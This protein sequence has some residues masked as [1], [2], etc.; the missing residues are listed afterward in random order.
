[1][2]REKSL[3]KKS[4][5]DIAGLAVPLAL[6]A[7][8]VIANH[9]GRAEASSVHSGR[10]IN[11]V[12]Y[13]KRKAEEKQLPPKNLVKE[14]YDEWEQ[15]RQTRVFL[16]YTEKDRQKAV[17]A[18]FGEARELSENAEYLEAIA[19]TFVARAANSGKPISEIIE[20]RNQYSYLNKG[21]K[22]AVKKGNAIKV[23]RSNILE[24]QAYKKCVDAVDYVLKY[25]V[26]KDNLYTHY[27]VLE[28]PGINA[29]FPDWARGEGIAPKK[30]IRHGNKTTRFY[31]L[32][33]VEATKQGYVYT[34]KV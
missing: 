30:I 25:G 1:M 19:S 5:C 2:K 11:L 29:D 31:D 14:C 3:L 32:T 8:G 27:F 16:D 21:D 22:N 15:Y 6:V 20:E 7:F 33:A 4:L 18:V 13:E 23:A 26:D 12:D 34:D 17:E 28:E 24:F 10:E 9:A